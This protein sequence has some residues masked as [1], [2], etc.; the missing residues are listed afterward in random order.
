M[1]KHYIRINEQNA[2]IKGFS[3]DFEQP[4]EGDI[5]INEYGQR[6][7]ELLGII[8]PN[9]YDNDGILKYKYIDSEVMERTEQDK[10]SEKDIIASE[11]IKA[12]ILQELSELDKYLPRGIE[13][14][15]EL[16]ISKGT[17][18]ENE[19]T[20]YFIDRKASKQALRNELQTLV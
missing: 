12:E 19:L 1:A 20:Q 16:L 15:S 3:S 13:D 6:H 2:I 5:C 10:Q 8:N 9:L 11:K 14:L 7:F 18:L 4:Q 17:I